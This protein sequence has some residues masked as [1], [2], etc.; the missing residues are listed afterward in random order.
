MSDDREAEP[1]SAGLATPRPIDAV[2]ALEDAFV[3][4][5][6]DAAAPIL[7]RDLQL[8]RGGVCTDEDLRATLAVVDGV[9]E[10]VDDRLL[11]Q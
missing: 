7:D 5:R 6:R 1:G 2:E 11:Q 10:Q 9:A 8:T 4:L 3:M